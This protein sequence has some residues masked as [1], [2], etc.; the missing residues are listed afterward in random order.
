MACALGSSGWRTFG[1][2][3]SYDSPYPR[4]S[5]TYYPYREHFFGGYAGQQRHPYPQMFSS[6]RPSFGDM[7]RSSFP[8]FGPSN[9]YNLSQGYPFL[10]TNLG[11]GAGIGSGMGYGSQGFGFSQSSYAGLHLPCGFVAASMRGRD[12]R[13][14]TSHHSSRCGLAGARGRYPSSQSFHDD[15][16][17]DDEEYA[18][19]IQYR[20]QSQR[21]APFRYSQQPTYGTHPMPRRC[22]GNDDYDDYDDNDD[23]FDDCSS[24]P[25][26]RRQ[27]HY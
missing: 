7:G 12:Y 19:F 11:M 10:G 9:P 17:N 1:R 27:R 23:E 21:Q 24:Y 26:Q 13:S 14:R 3:G 2:S 20:S 15:D 22:C 18:P 16:D 25:A 6:H 5:E 8:T 4:S